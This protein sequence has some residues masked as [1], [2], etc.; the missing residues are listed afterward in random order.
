VV[1]EKENRTLL[2]AEVSRAFGRP[3]TLRCV[4]PDRETAK[5]PP[6]DVRPLVDQ[7]IAWFQGD[8]IERAPRA[9]RSAE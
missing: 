6:P 4:P 5:G 1:E 7:A 8:V 9:Q 3:L 2:G